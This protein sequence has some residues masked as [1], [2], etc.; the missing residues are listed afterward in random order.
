M[1]DE[2]LLMKSLKNKNYYIA[3]KILAKDGFIL[4]NKHILNYALEQKVNDKE[5]I[6]LLV[7]RVEN[8]NIKDSLII[9]C[10]NSDI[11]INI[12]DLL[13]E[14]GADIN[15]FDSGGRSALVITCLTGCKN[16]FK[17]LLEKGADVNIQNTTG[18][19]TLHTIC[20]DEQN[21]EYVELLLDKGADVNIKTYD[22]YTALMLACIKQCNGIVKLLLEKDAIVDV[23][24]LYNTINNDNKYI[25]NLLI[26][27]S[28]VNGE[29]DGIDEIIDIV[30]KKEGC[31]NLLNF[32]LEKVGNSYPGKKEI[33]ENIV[34]DTALIL[35]QSRH[36]LEK[37]LKEEGLVY[38]LKKIEEKKM[39]ILYLFEN[40]KEFYKKI[41][42]LCKNEL[43]YDGKQINRDLFQAINNRNI[44]LI[45][46]LLDENT[47]VYDI[48]LLKNAFILL[49]S[50]EILT[51][52]MILLLSKNKDG[53][54]NF[55]FNKN[56]NVL[57]MACERGYENIVK[58][59]L[60]NEI[61]V[62]DKNDEGDT[63]LL[64]ACEK[65]YENIIILLLKKD[66]NINEKNEN[67]G[68]TA[69]DLLKNNEDILKLVLENDKVSQETKNT[70]LVFTCYEK[71]S[72][73]Q[74]V[75]LL[76]ENGAQVYATYNNNSSLYFALKNNN[77]EI[78]KLLLGK[79]AMNKSL[80]KE[81]YELYFNFAFQ[82]FNKEIIELLLFFLS[83]QTTEEEFQNIIDSVQIDFL[84][85][86]KS[87]SLE[88]QDINIL[89]KN[90]ISVWEIVNSDKSQFEKLNIALEKEWNEIV[91]LIVMKDDFN[92]DC[93]L[94]SYV[95]KE[96]NTNDDCVNLF[97]ILLEKNKQ[98]FDKKE[99]CDI[100]KNANF[101]ILR[102]LI[103][104]EPEIIKLNCF[105]NLD[106]NTT[107]SEYNLLIYSILNFKTLV[108]VLEENKKIY[109]D[110]IL[111]KIWKEC[112]SNFASLNCW[113]IIQKHI[114]FEWII[115]G[116]FVLKYKQNK[117]F[118]KMII[119]DDDDKH[120]Y[121]IIKIL[122][123]SDEEESQKSIYEIIKNKEID[124]LSILYNP[125][126]AGSNKIDFIE[127]L[128]KGKM[129]VIDILSDFYKNKKKNKKKVDQIVSS[130]L[131]DF[132]E[133]KYKYSSDIIELLCK[134]D[135]K[136]LI[137]K[138]EKKDETIKAR[139]LSVSE[140]ASEDENIEDV[141]MIENIKVKDEDLI[142]TILNKP[143]SDQTRNIISL[144]NLLLKE[145]IQILKEKIE[146]KRKKK[147]E[148]TNN[149][150]RL[151]V[152]NVSLEN[153]KSF[154]DILVDSINNNEHSKSVLDYIQTILYNES[155]Y[156]TINLSEKKDYI[157]SSKTYNN[158]ILNK[159]KYNVRQYSNKIQHPKETI[160]NL[161]NYQKSMN[162]NKKD[163]TSENIEIIST[164]FKNLDL[165][166][167][168]V[169]DDY[170]DLLK[171]SLTNYEFVNPYIL[172]EK[173]RE[174]INLLVDEIQKKY[175]FEF[176]RDF[177]SFDGD[178]FEYIGDSLLK[179]IIE[180]QYNSISLTEFADPKELNIHK[181]HIQT[182]NFLDRLMENKNIKKEILKLNN[183]FV[184]IIPNGGSIY[185][186]IRS[187]KIY[188]FNKEEWCA[189]FLEGIITTLF[190]HRIPTDDKDKILSFEK[191][192]TLIVNW[193][194]H[195]N[196]DDE[197]IKN[198]NICKNNIKNYFLELQQNMKSKK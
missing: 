125:I 18:Y 36:I 9:A 151:V 100:I 89:L 121:Q 4:S 184:T 16:I 6:K 197:I 58:L 77:K 33:L 186:M 150:I 8:V 83:K 192:L 107:S 174:R 66:A 20:F 196:T 170:E 70:S 13:L 79:G 176:N 85:F 3:K 154:I 23:L 38:A 104:K 189:D 109:D 86:V 118:L 94:L 69:F 180:N 60:E 12:I 71:N 158:K 162:E 172:K 122:L 187:N 116:E 10:E 108:E 138:Q 153:F 81:N 53:V 41:I 171:I 193:W 139:E 152:Q 92:L 101:D 120:F 147:E 59:I 34:N 132:N 84:K 68:Y 99:M 102:I 96:C 76:I 178:S 113:S 148:K 14:R 169:S 140:D 88:L 31:I 161:T 130:I 19:T 124:S 22:N 114:K 98:E 157:S 87:T 55:K 141:S 47:I 144:V 155:I 25:T 135:T 30:F 43:K 56:Y 146:N 80:T 128:K 134:I 11:D 175:E 24:S 179:M 72:N 165:P 136:F 97:K 15:K 168:F 106:K 1:S 40:N 51:K 119:D 156:K 160:D 52:I 117:D 63:A 32:L 195:F 112:I 90:A 167:E 65:N 103:D 181:E 131:N 2:H 177:F 159:L 45:D 95:S 5:I 67:K 82:K 143:D 126:F 115:D 194:S 27:S 173:Y 50:E 145:K 123:K 48:K 64:I 183:N 17:L 42:E 93:I 75:K 91:R 188:D 74:I 46:V 190:L 73:I 37:F 39:G 127:Q 142:T 29:M 57:M 35:V 28:S 149:D 129:I 49:N 198:I 182:N 21:I 44:D 185:K 163:N 164:I 105:L 133:T 166:K 110:D 191:Q 62:N 78:V 26:Q 7:D 111:K 137:L 54:L 61:N